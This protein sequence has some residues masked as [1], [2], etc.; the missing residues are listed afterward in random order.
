MTNVVVF[1]AS[2]FVQVLCLLAEAEARP[3]YCAVGHCRRAE[4]RQLLVR[5]VSQEIPRYGPYLVVRTVRERVDVTRW[6]SLLPD[7]A[8]GAMALW[9]ESGDYWGVVN[10]DN[11]DLLPLDKILLAGP[12]MD[13]FGMSA[14]DSES[15]TEAQE[16]PPAV[17]QQF[18]R[19][20]RALGMETW[21][22]L[23]SLTFAVIGCGRAGSLAAH[24]LVKS[25][26]CNLILLDPDSVEAHN[27]PEMDGVTLS[28][29]GRAKVEV[30]GAFLKACGHGDSLPLA[31]VACVGALPAAWKKVL[32]ADVFVCCVDSDAARLSCGIM[33]SLYH[34]LLLDI[35]S[36]IPI[37]PAA[38]PSPV[39][40]MGSDMRLI[41]PGSGCLLCL[42]GVSDY[43]AASKELAGLAAPRQ[44]DWWLTRRGSLRTLNSVAVHLGLQLLL[45]LLAGHLSQST[46]LQVEYGEEGQ[47]TVRHHQTQAHPDTC[48]LCGKA[49]LG[50]V[51]L[52]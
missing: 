9:P 38:Q 12:R 50:D 14:L 5:G 17:A 42:G 40:R 39:V 22:K 33:A 6:L 4:R 20:V 48:A 35:G 21:E 47:V 10:G 15:G 11:G 32:A 1:P 13:V 24:T 23:T 43:A 44:E 30:L 25:G 7:G 8:I 41:V 16:I 19:T 36:G 51:G 49:G 31:I 34:K 18:S 26:V 37:T 29:I 27:I 52:A 45:D 28:D 2:L 3:V 46:W